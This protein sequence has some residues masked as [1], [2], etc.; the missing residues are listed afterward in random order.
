MDA[1]KEI[2]WDSLSEAELVAAE[3]V[4]EPS[5]QDIRTDLRQGGNTRT[6]EF[7]AD[8]WSTR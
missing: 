4:S 1:N 5:L 7:Y 6:N 3:P 2:D 8:V